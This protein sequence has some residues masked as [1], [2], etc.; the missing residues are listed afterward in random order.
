LGYCILEPA[1]D[2]I[3]ISTCGGTPVLACQQSDLDEQVQAIMA[4]LSSYEEPETTKVLYNLGEM[5][6]KEG[7][8]RARW[9]DSKAAILVGFSGTLLTLLVVTS[10]NWK[11]EIEGWGAFSLFVAI[12][13]LLTAGFFA[14]WA[15]LIARFEWFNENAGWFP[16]EY[17]QYP[18]Q[19][20]RYYLLAM[21]R[22]HWSHECVNHKKSSRI[23]NAQR[24]LEGGAVFLAL[25]LL[26]VLWGRGVGQVLSSLPDYLWRWWL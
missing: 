26:S 18:D 20:T 1:G 23:A 4:R 19:L 25:P 7:V 8:E 24:L 22:V 17:L 21:Y 14:L 16:T 15:L 3:D 5:L 2:V 6:V 11:T 10:S 12:L 9:L 13:C